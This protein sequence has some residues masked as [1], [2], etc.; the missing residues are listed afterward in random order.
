MN[1]VSIPKSAFSEMLSAFRYFDI[2]D[3]GCGYDRLN[4][5]MKMIQMN[6]QL[7]DDDI[8]KVEKWA[9]EKYYKN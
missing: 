9:Y 3:E 6:H 1:K 7:S 8:G 5:K 2:V 4:A